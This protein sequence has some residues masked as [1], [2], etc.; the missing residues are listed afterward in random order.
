MLSIATGWT[1]AFLLGMRHASEPDHLAAVATLVPD[2]RSA[3]SAARLGFAWGLGHSLSLLIFGG[4]LLT[5]RLQLSARTADLFELVVAAM[6][7]FLGGRSLHRAL[8]PSRQP[9]HAPHPHA[10]GLG[11]KPLLVGMV[12]GLAGSGSL[13]ALVLAN[14]PTPWAGLG[15]L[16]CFAGGSILA[17]ALLAGLA[18][19][20]LRWLARGDS[21]QAAVFAVAGLLSVGLGFSY[22]LS[23]LSRLIG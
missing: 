5:L 16:L 9:D 7:L 1:L 17:M 13:A 15:Y 10:H 8:R 12:H 22:G 3:R 6:L 14:M 2:Q 11:R 18:G 19:A 23:I 21:A 20:P 4:L